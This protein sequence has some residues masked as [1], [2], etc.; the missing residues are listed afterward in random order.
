MSAAPATGTVIIGAGQAGLA[1]SSVLRA[2]DH[3]HVLLERGRIGER[4]RSERWDSLSLLTPAWANR[5]PGDREPA[6]PDA[7]LSRDA[8]VRSLEDYASDIGAPVLERTPVRSVRRAGAGF[9]IAGARGAWRAA[10]VVVATGFCDVPAL[11]RAAA[12]VPAGVLHLHASRYRDPDRL[13]RGGV[14]VVGSGATGHQLAYELATAGRR[15]V[16][17]VGRHSRALRRYRGRDTFAWL[18]AL[19]VLSETREQARRDPRKPAD[20]SLPLDGR[21]G[22]R[23]LDLNVLAGL[24]VRIAGR[25]QGFD[26][27]VARFDPALAERVADAEDRFRKMLERIDRH[28]HEHAL[29]GHVPAAE[30]PAPIELEAPPASVDLAAEN[31]RTVI[32]ATGYHRH[33]PW[34][35]VPAGSAGGEIVHRHGVTPVPGLFVLGML[36]QRRRSSHQIGGVGADALELA[37]HILEGRRELAAAA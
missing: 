8:F 34:L 11:P 20:P 3:P 14:L 29:D 13:P 31:I 1:L 9:E 32:W 30:R 28:V 36:W 33:H 26:G 35:Q 10:N 23:Q 4:W 21:D 37:G 22:G 15:V 17:A 16:F 19:G 18:R 12:R 6:D 2:A 7:F 24:G 25:L 27:A 5:L